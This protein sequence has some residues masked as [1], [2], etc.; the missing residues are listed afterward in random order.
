MQDIEIRSG[1]IRP[2]ETVKEAYELIKSDYWLLFAIW[3]V[4]GMIGGV[5]LMIAAG[6]MT[7]GTFYAYLRKIDGHPANFDDL[8]KGMRWFGSGLVIMAFIIVPIILVYAL[9]YIP[10]VLAAVMG[11][12]L[13]ETELMQL[14][15]GAFIVD[16]F[17]IIIMVCVHTLLIF[18]F[19]LMVDKNIGA[20]KAMSISARAVFK[21]LGGV[22][23]MIAINFVLVLAGYA[24]LCVGVYFVIPIILASSVV[25]YRKIFPA[26]LRAVN[27]EPPPPGAFSGGFQ[28]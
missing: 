26:P 28:Q 27:F 4:G 21:N 14:L 18:S 3:L 19:P 11:S 10:F 17:L 9:I 13:S 5:S 15:I 6:A 2:I 7:A 23:G 16:F 20:F 12:K 25:A 22:S 24:A 1:V 8:W